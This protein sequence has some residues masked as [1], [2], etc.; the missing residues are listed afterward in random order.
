MLDS[1][2]RRITMTFLLIPHFVLDVLK[3]H[4]LPSSTILDFDKLREV[5][6]VNDMAAL[7]NLQECWSSILETNRM[8]HFYCDNETSLYN[9]WNNSATGDGK[10]FLD[11]VFS[12]VLVETGQNQKELSERLFDAQSKSENHQK[13]YELI[14]MGN[15]VFGVVIYPGFFPVEKS[16]LSKNILKDIVRAMYLYYVQSRIARSPFFE[17]YV[18]S[19]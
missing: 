8:K 7:N 3:R 15:K 1:I 9:L 10:T 17:L 2:V 12:Q 11:N 16:T 5:V 18:K 13:A 6:S 4:N 14:D 19:L